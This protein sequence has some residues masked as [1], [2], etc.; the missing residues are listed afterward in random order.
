MIREVRKL[1]MDSALVMFHALAKTASL[2]KEGMV[3]SD[4]NTGFLS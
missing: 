2:F 1:Q 3:L 4:L